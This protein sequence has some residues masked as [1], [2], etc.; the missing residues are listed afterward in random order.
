[1]N[2]NIN[3]P[4]ARP[5]I[6]ERERNAVLEVLHSPILSMG[7]KLRAFEEATAAFAGTKHAVAVSSG[8]AGLH[9]L[10]RALGLKEGD[11]VITTPFSFIASANCLLFERIKP[12]FADIDPETLNIDPEQIAA[13][14]T[15]RTK[16]ILPV[17]VF[18][19]PAEMEAINEL[20]RAH[21]LKVIEDSC[22]AIGARYRGRPAGSLGDGGVFAF[23]P[24]KQITTGEGAVIVTDD[25][26]VAR[27]C[28]SMRNQ[29]RG[30]D[31]AWLN[32]V[33]LGFN[34]R[35]DELSAALGIVQLQRLEEILAKRS[36][37]AAAYNERL[38]EI[39]EIK[40]PSI[41]PHVEMSWFVYV[42]RFAPAIDRDKAA[43]FLQE[44]GVSCRAYFSPIHLQPFYRQE[45][46]YKEGDFPLTE[47][48]SASTLA[49]PFYNELLPEEIDYIGTC[50]E[51]AVRVC[52]KK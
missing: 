5:D 2:C 52:T 39:P 36:R 41:S 27:L 51:E 1:M 49:L 23:Y 46:G 29:G 47:A 13:K 19:Q 17:H 3:I 6:T 40:L 33:R 45:F 28:D 16:G 4:L 24:N 37:V 44:K 20:A 38:Q 10:V 12:V 26:E 30:E 14:I 7:P 8:T 32:H 9:L 11:E 43:A 18:G 22:E 35:L 34:Y 25:A 15:P 31:G 50:L 21:D 48:V 42:I